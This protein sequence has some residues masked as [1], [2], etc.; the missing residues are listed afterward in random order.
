MNDLKYLFNAYV[1]DR[2][3][4]YCI[5]SNLKDLDMKTVK[6]MGEVKEIPMKDLFGFQLLPPPVELT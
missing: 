4:T 1:K 3:F 2:K 5:I 6:S